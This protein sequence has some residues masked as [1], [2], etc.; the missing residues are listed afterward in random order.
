MNQDKVSQTVMIQ[1]VEHI[2]C[3]FMYSKRNSVP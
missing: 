2:E 3:N 1:V